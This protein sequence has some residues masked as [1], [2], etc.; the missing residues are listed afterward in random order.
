M[1]DNGQW[2]TWNRNDQ[3]SLNI[4]SQC[5]ETMSTESGHELIAVL[6][7]KSLLATVGDDW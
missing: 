2:R 3:Y 6:S 4:A 5:A 7:Y 1:K